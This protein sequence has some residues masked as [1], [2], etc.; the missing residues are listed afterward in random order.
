MKVLGPQPFKD[1]PKFVA[2]ADLVVLFQSASPAAQGQLPAK[3]FD[4]MS[5]AKPIIASSVSD[6]PVILE[7]CGEI[8]EPGDVD[9]LAR[10]IAVL[11]DDPGRASELGRRARQKCLAEYSYDALGPKLRDII[12][13][14]VRSTRRR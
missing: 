4:A 14:V 3:V 7:G 10:A 13:G 6:L 1:T 8:V 5:M 2:A 11:L 9:S 12:E